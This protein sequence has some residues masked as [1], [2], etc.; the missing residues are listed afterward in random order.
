MKNL[1]LVLVLSALAVLA[2]GSLAA[3]ANGSDSTGAPL[4]APSNC[5]MAFTGSTVKPDAPVAGQNAKSSISGG[6]VAP[7]CNATPKPAGC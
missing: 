5:T 7:D 4:P 2:F 6:A 3:F 1:M